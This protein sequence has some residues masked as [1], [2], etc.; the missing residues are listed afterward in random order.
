MGLK[1]DIYELRKE[2]EEKEKLKEKEDTSKEELYEA[3]EYSPLEKKIMKKVNV[4]QKVF[5]ILFGILACYIAISILATTKNLVLLPFSLCIMLAAFSAIARS[6]DK[7]FLSN[8]I[9]K[10][11]IAIFL[12]MWMG[13][14]GFAT[15]SILKTETGIHWYLI[16]SVFWIAGFYMIYRYLI[17]KK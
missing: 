10:M 1:E 11:C 7:E 17:K 14:V 6:F 8:S 5:S 15:Y 9:G 16:L 4:F 2:R 12:L 13:F 3:K